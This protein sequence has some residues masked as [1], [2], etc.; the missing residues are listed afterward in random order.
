MGLTGL[1]SRCQWAAFLSGGCSKVCFLAHSGLGRIQSQEVVG[2]VVG[3]H[4]SAGSKGLTLPPRGF[5]QAFAHVCR[6]LYLRT[7]KRASNPSQAVIST[8]LLLL[9]LSLY[10]LG[11]YYI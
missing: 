8:S 3:L 11:R 1:K 5:S 9:C 10:R 6:T 7:S 4:V 2:L